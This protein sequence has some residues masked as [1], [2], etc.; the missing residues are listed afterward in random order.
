MFSTVF[1]SNKINSIDLEL[2]KQMRQLKSLNLAK[3]QLSTIQPGAFIDLNNLDT[4]DLSFNQFTQLHP[5]LFEFQF[6]LKNVILNGN[7]FDTIDPNMFTFIK[8]NLNCLK[9]NYVLLFG[10][11]ISFCTHL[12][13]KFAS[14][15]LQPT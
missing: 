14:F 11:Q 8:G 1:L 12:R 4:L 10:P 5:K 9:N 15:K 2:F 7:K 13:Y 3:N 6:R